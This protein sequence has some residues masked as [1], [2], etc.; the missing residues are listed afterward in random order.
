MK[1]FP[2]LPL[3]F[4]LTYLFVAVTIIVNYKE[5]NYA[6]AIGTAVMIFF[7]GLYFVIRKLKQPSK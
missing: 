6:A 5:N 2:I 3:I 4:I 7:G 1:L